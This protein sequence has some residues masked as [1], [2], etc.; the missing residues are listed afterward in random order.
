MLEMETFWLEHGE[1]LGGGELD[2]LSTING[3]EVDVGNKGQEENGQQ[4]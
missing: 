1:V 3:D 4:L 2:T